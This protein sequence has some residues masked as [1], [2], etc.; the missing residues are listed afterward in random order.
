MKKAAPELSFD[1]IEN[2][3]KHRSDTELKKAYWLFNVVGRS[4]MV[5]LGRRFA[6]PS[7]SFGLKGVIKNTI[8]EHFCGGESIKECDKTI[9]RLADG[10][11]GTILDLSVEG[12]TNEESLDATSK[13]LVALA[14][15]AAHNKDIPFCV[16]KVTGVARFELLEKVSAEEELSESETAEWKR[17]VARVEAICKQAHD[18]DVPVLIDAE[19]SWVQEAIDS[20]ARDMMAKFNKR[21]AIVFNTYQMYRHD[22]LAYLKSDYEKAVA[23]KYLLGVKLVR[24]AYME[25]ERA[26]ASAKGYASPINKDK[27]A[28]DRA[29]NQALE[30]CIKHI[31]RFALCAGTHNADSSMYLADLMSK[32]GLANNDKR[33]WFA[34]LLGMSDNI[35]YNLAAA[36]YNVAKYVPY[37]PVKEVLPYLIRRAQENTS[38]KGQTGRELSL[39]KDELQRRKDVVKSV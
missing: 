17:A 23:G 9:H 35:S 4:W 11:V 26:R 14:K 32:A 15:H 20:V 13:E 24:G 36:G 38:V 37:G 25:K 2:A 34:Q 21:R 31:D 1:N 19:E 7:L 6:A 12:K 27:P 22:R 30:F 10:G 39:I 16:F 18:G 33:V 5:G 29:Y 8:F 3:F 28:T